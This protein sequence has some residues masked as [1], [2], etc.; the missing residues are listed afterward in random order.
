MYHS[1]Q[2]VKTYL[3]STIVGSRAPRITKVQ[4]LETDFGYHCI[5]AIAT[6][7]NALLCFTIKGKLYYTKRAAP[8]RLLRLVSTL[9]IFLLQRAGYTT[10]KKLRHRGYRN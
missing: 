7:F 6:S 9:S 8:S 3:V 5:A 2:V 4:E 10:P 1:L